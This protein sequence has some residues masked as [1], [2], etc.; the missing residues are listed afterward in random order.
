MID[1]AQGRKYNKDLI[2]DTEAEEIVKCFQTILD[3][4]PGQLQ[5]V[6]FTELIEAME[7]SK[8]LEKFAYR[9]RDKR[10]AAEFARIKNEKGQLE[11]EMGVIEDENPEFGFKC[12]HYSVTESAGQVEITVKRKRL[13]AGDCVGVRT[14]DLTAKSPKDYTGINM[15]LQFKPR[16]DTAKL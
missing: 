1:C 6:P 15:T 10:N 2:G 3:K 16:E 4:T 14:Q 12:L 11:D 8:L 7:P 5:S 9:R 13:D